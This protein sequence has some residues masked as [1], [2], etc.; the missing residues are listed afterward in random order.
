MTEKR[1]DREERECV[2]E[3]GEGEEKRESPRHMHPVTIPPSL[4]VGKA[5]AHH[6]PR[7]GCP[8][9]GTSALALT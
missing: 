5:A 2:W 1:D 6:R 4:C 9:S 8:R 3:G 7:H